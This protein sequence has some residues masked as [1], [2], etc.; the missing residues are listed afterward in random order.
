M[1]PQQANEL[2]IRINRRISPQ[3]LTPKGMRDVSSALQGISDAHAHVLFKLIDR[4][5]FHERKFARACDYAAHP[6][7]IRDIDYEAQMLSGVN[8]EKFT[9]EQI[10]ESIYRCCEV[11]E[12]GEWKP[13]EKALRRPV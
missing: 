8:L 5:G 2:T 12:D 9:P 6:W 11:F 4:W 10:L 7:K 13:I 1:T 3:A